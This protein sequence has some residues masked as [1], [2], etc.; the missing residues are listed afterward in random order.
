MASNRVFLGVV[1]AIVVCASVPAEV[2]AQRGQVTTTAILFA[3]GDATDDD[4][5]RVTRALRRSVA[6][7]RRV[8]FA[9]LADALEVGEQ[10]PDEVE[11]AREA[12][13][14]VAEMLRSG[15]GDGAAAR[16]RELIEVFEANLVHVPRTE[17]AD[18]YM[19]AAV[20]ECVARRVRACRDG[21]RRVVTFRES[22]QYDI[23]RYPVD[24]LTEFD[25]VRERVVAGARGLLEVSTIPT[26]GEVF[27]DGRAY[28]AAPTVVDG[29]LA[30]D[31]YLTVKLAGYA[32]DVRRVTVEPEGQASVEVEL[33]RSNRALLIEQDLP[34]IRRE[35]GGSRTGRY[36]LRLA[37]TL[38]VN[39]AVLGIVR[40]EG[41]RLEIALYLYD[42]RTRFLLRRLR[43]SVRA[44]PG[45]DPRG[46]D[47]LGAEVYEG[48]DLRGHV[49]APED[50]PP[51]QSGP[52]PLYGRWWFW[53]AIGVV[54]TAGVVT[55]V[56]IGGQEQSVPDGFV[57]L[58]G[59]VR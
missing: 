46:I 19:L 36:T 37:S 49:A 3:D 17:L 1:V 40:R 15:D 29:L 14:A 47:R 25:A 44:P 6:K 34:R 38:F 8:R 58:G 33:T 54:V 28:G 55:A 16:A 27:V 23:D 9:D 24:Y 31:H 35:A 30:G 22:L 18:V 39:Q 5:A 52:T 59:S 56:V 26:G 20:A 13:D 51:E 42:L 21:F 57:R 7:V 50:R 41:S 53:T 4:V 43:R 2:L 32:R 12:R 11:A 45:R 10:A 48:V